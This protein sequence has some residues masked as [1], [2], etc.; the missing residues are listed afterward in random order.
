MRLKEIETIIKNYYPIVLTEVSEDIYLDFQQKRLDK[1]KQQAAALNLDKIKLLEVLN[2]RF[3]D[4][5]LDESILNPDDPSIRIS[6]KIRD[7]P[8][9]SVQIVR[10][11]LADVGTIVLIYL[12]ENGR[13]T[14]RLIVKED[15]ANQPISEIY[16]LYFNNLD[17]EFLDK[18][19]LQEKHSFQS[20]VFGFKEVSVYE[21]IFGSR[22]LPIDVM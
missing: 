18:E 22:F 7:N 21:L 8:F 4:S 14:E 3:P 19:Q 1:C 12:N 20:N 13:F 6:V 11:L 17:L 16:D 2:K 5:V 9:L 10:S 15:F